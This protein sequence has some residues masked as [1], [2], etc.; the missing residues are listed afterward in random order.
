MFGIL[1]LWGFELSGFNKVYLGIWEES[2]IR[3][4]R[5]VSLR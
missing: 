1:G 3:V 2:F 5:D 4:L